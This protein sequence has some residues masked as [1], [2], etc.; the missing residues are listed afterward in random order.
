[1]KQSFIFI[2]EAQPFLSKDRKKE[3]NGKEK[4]FVLQKWPFHCL[5]EAL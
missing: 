1:V 3:L 5:K 4:A 2:V